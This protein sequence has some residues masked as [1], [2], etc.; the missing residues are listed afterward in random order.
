MEKYREQPPVKF[1]EKHVGVCYTNAQIKRS[2][3][4]AMSRPAWYPARGQGK[5]W[6]CL[7]AMEGHQQTGSTKNIMAA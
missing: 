1:T 4:A 7:T 6:S 5:F 2:K 3:P